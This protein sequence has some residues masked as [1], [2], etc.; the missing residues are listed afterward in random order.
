M[1]ITAKYFVRRDDFRLDVNIDF[2]EN[3]VT[4]FY[5][6]SGSG[7][8]TILRAIAG[9]DRHKDGFLRF[10]EEIWQNGDVYLPAHRRPIGYVFQEAILFP[11]LS[12]RRNLEYGFKRSRGKKDTDILS[13]SIQLLGIEKFLP[14][15]PDSLS[16]GERQ[17]VAIARALAVGPELLL[18]DEPLSSLDDAGKREIMPYIASLQRESGIPIVYVSH[19]LDEIARLADSVVLMD[20]GSVLAHEKIAALLT[21]F[22]L[23]VAGA[24]DAEA[25][26]DA[27]VVEKD[28]EFGLARLEVG[29]LCLTVPD[30]RRGVGEK[31]RVRISAS[32]VSI[33]LEH[34][35]GTSIQNILPA[36][37]DDILDLGTAH[38][39]VRLMCDKVPILSRIT[40]KSASE[41]DIR[42]G[43]EVFAQVKSVVLLD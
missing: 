26:V 12:V 31:T 15:S 11:H 4:A 3:G 22:D 33:A 40:R 42:R 16:G 21:R 18:M 30:S 43:K 13:R 2:P 6:P 34:H 24:R 38:I 1:T 29:A 20:N 37:V 7:K 39:V 10:G 32:D 9:L 41:L 35:R 36:R 5:G 17:R 23:P 8:T 28:E 19:N 27:V 25:V 14:R